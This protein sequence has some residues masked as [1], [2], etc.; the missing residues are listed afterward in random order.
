[1]ARKSNSA[2]GLD[3]IELA[4]ARN[5][6]SQEGVDLFIGEVAAE[7]WQKF[8]SFYGHQEGYEW[9]GVAE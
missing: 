9:V 8:L 6:E 2:A 5:K 4:E 3:D 7:A 1:M